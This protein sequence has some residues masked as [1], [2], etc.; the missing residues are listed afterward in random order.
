[1]DGDAQVVV[2]GQ[3]AP[4]EAAGPAVAPLTLA[5]VFNENT[6]ARVLSEAIFKKEA[7]EIA[8]ASSPSEALR[9]AAG[10]SKCAGSFLCAVPMVRAFKMPKMALSRALCRGSTALPLC[11]P[12]TRTTVGRGVKGYLRRRT[13]YT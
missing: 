7:G 2:D 6:S 5:N 1:M 4:E 11:R 9:F 3:M 12:P 13:G 10:L 8:A